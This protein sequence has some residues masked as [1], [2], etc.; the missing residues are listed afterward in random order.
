MSITFE[1]SFN[2]DAD[3]PELAAGVNRV[4]G[5]AF[6]RRDDAMYAGTLFGLPCVLGRNDYDDDGLIRWSDYRYQLSNS[7]AAGSTLRQIQMET[8]FLAMF[9]L[10]SSLGIEDG[11]L[12]YES[13][14]V[15]A[16]Y[17]AVDGRWCDLETATEIDP[18]EHLLVLNERLDR[19][20]DES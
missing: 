8:L 9:A 4:L 3:L 2:T 5:T 16:R 20:Y 10:R 13:Q 11:M 1:F 19:S 14:R 15:L 18:V 7:S 17:A 12:T 6:E